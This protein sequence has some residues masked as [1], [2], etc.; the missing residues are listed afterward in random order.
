MTMTSVNGMFALPFTSPVPNHQPTQPKNH[1]ALDF[2]GFRS[3]A[4][5]GFEPAT[6][7]L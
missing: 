4:G 5:A 1:K 3:I 7:G 2:Q 6:F